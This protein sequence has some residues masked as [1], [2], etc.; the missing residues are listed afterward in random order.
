MADGIHFEIVAPDRLVMSGQARSATV[1]AVEGYFTALA[2]HAPVLTIL[3]PGF[4]N[5]V[6]IDNASHT[7]F[8][9]GG[10]AEVSPK[11]LTILAEESREI[12]ELDRGKI[13]A[14]LRAAQDE[15]AKAESAEARNAAQTAVDALRNF[16]DEA[17]HM[18]PPVSM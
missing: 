5:I 7:F 14:E 15:L 4:V 6:D 2:D 17:M 3:K 16:L 12:S 18:Q 1:P 11:G 13:E 9:R 10:S 8:V